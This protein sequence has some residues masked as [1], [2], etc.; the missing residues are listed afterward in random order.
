MMR[1]RQ[2]EARSAHVRM[3]VGGVLVQ[4]AQEKLVAWQALYRRDQQR[5]EVGFFEFGR[6]S[7]TLG[8][9]LVQDSNG[10]L[11]VINVDRIRIDEL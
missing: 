9:C 1:G 10:R 8:L 11:V 4:L 6:E 5:G 3:L 2:Y 7:G